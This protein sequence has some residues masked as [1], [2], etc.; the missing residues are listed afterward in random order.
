MTISGSGDVT[1][2]SVS[3]YPVCIPDRSVELKIFGELFR[4]GLGFLDSC[5]TK[6]TSESIE[7]IELLDVIFKVFEN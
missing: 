6:D 3:I 5:S 1:E 4:C 2:E 7:M